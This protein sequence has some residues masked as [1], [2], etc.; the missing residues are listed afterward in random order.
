MD[1]MPLSRIVAG[2]L[3]IL[4]L[5]GCNMLDQQ[6]RK[7]QARFFDTNEVAIEQMA[8]LGLS[9]ED[10]DREIASAVG[11]L[12][13]KANQGGQVSSDPVLERKIESELIKPKISGTKK[14]FLLYERARYK[15]ALGQDVAADSDFKAAVTV[16]EPLRTDGR[17]AL[18]Q[19]LYTS[20]SNFLYRTGD[21]AGVAIYRA[22]YD[23]VA[24]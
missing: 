22:K 5:S 16:A 15:S 11:S 7:L 23:K 24:H 9:P 12:Y 19:G 14:A 21:D 18:L 8:M 3:M 6:N 20:Y 1:R 2:S 4:S 13:H 17:N 10:T